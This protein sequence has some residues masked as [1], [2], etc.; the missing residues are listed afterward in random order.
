MYHSQPPRPAARGSSRSLVHRRP[1]LLAA[2]VTL[3]VGTAAVTVAVVAP[4]P[5]PAG[6]PGPAAVAPA[7][8]PQIRDD[9]L[10]VTY[11]LPDG[12]TELLGD[13]FIFTISSGAVVEQPAGGGALLAVGVLDSS[14]SASAEPTLAAAARRLSIGFGEF[15]IPVPGRHTDRVDGAT[16]V[17]GRT[18]WDSGYRVVPT[19]PAADGGT[20][21]ATVVEDGARRLYA[22]VFVSPGDDGPARAGADGG[23]LA[24]LRVSVPAPGW[25]SRSLD[26]DECRAPAGRAQALGSAENRQFREEG[27]AAGEAVV[28]TV[29]EARRALGEC[30][31]VAARTLGGRDHRQDRVDVADVVA[32]EPPLRVDEAG[33]RTG[34]AVGLVLLGDQADLVRRHD[35]CHPLHVVAPFVGDPDRGGRV[36]VRRV[37]LPQLVLADGGEGRREARPR[38][39]G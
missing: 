24:P 6:L 9:T 21:H 23:L 8:G 20:V 11:A 25:T 29:L 19:D 16:T 37:E 12:W 31:V 22:I 10:G 1:G 36:P 32:F 26:G 38:S 4:S 28:E 2:L 39:S 5:A 30:P 17:D 18:G 7:A 14:I 33:P 13:D 3:L 35:A 34:D 27:V 15:L